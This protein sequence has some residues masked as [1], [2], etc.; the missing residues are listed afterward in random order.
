VFKTIKNYGYEPL[1]FNNE[2]FDYKSPI[3]VRHI[4][5]GAVL[6]RTT[7]QMRVLKCTTCYDVRQPLTKEQADEYAQLRMGICLKWASPATLK[8][9]WQCKDG[10]TWEAPFSRLH[11]SESWCPKCAYTNRFSDGFKSESNIRTLARKQLDS[12]QRR[13]KQ[14][15]RIC[16]LTIDD[17]LLARTSACC[18]CKRT[19]VGLDRIDNTIGHEKTNCVPACLRCN[20]MRGKYISHTVML[21]VG[22]VLEKIDP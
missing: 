15:N 18:Y 17:I 16:N 2:Y 11:L 22:K 10:H 12:Y 9:K 13:D 6:V 5:C 14:K 7:P 19:A 8:S 21:E 3:R 4:K 1:D 20:W